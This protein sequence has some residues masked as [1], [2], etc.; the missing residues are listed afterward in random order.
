MSQE[1]KNFV[2]A[3]N[4]RTE[5]ELFNSYKV[6]QRNGNC[7]SGRNRAQADTKEGSRP[8]GHS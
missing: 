1:M 2:A 6:E 7:H 8:E 5:N 3:Q 4:P